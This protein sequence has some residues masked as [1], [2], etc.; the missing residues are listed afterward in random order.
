MCV[1]VEIE[2]EA[3]KLWEAEP[4]TFVGTCIQGRWAAATSVLGCEMG[5]LTAR[6]CCQWNKLLVCVRWQ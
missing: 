4:L 6:G 5:W 3:V 1:C 2:L